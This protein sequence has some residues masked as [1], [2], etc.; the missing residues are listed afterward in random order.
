MKRI[1]IKLLYC[2]RVIKCMFVLL[3]ARV[4]RMA[5]SAIYVMLYKRITRQPVQSLLCYIKG[6]QGNLCNL[7]LT[8]LHYAR[9]ASRPHARPPYQL[10]A[11]IFLLC[12]FIIWWWMAICVTIYLKQLRTSFQTHNCQSIRHHLCI[13]L[14]FKLSFLVFLGPWGM[15]RVWEDLLCARGVIS[16]MTDIVISRALIHSNVMAAS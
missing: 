7:C 3:Y 16:A 9:V 5:T 8:T 4:A 10:H 15:A 2:S 11:T 12:T 14:I 6:L 1:K 13:F